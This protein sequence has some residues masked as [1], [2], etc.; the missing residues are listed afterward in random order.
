VRFLNDQ[1]GVLFWYLALGKAGDE[2]VVVSNDL[3]DADEPW[4]EDP[5]ERQ[6]YFCARSFE[7]FL[8]RFWLESEIYFRSQD[9]TPLTPA[10]QRYASHYREGPEA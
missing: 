7:E 1:Q 5:H 3:L 2:G 6:I 9:G 10:M 4:L 8:Y